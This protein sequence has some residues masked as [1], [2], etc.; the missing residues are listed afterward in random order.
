M[1][2]TSHAL[3]Y[4]S[5]REMEMARMQEQDMKRPGRPSTTTLPN[6]ADKGRANM[7]GSAAGHAPH[8]P[9]MMPKSFKMGSHLSVS[10]MIP[11]Y[12]KG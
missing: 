8:H 6:I 9:A 4:G 1:A 12:K 5:L 3:G 2:A 7:A 10:E 11:T